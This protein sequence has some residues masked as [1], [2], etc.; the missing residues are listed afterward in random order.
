MDYK[1]HK[2]VPPYWLYIQSKSLSATDA[3]MSKPEICFLSDF[4]VSGWEFV[5]NELLF[6][7]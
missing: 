1:V 3:V 6:G 5:I 4:F 2:T 7:L